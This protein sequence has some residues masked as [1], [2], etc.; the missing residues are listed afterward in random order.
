MTDIV[1]ANL[2]V[3]TSGR[4]FS[5][6]LHV[7]FSG[8]FL[9]G[10][11][12][13]DDTTPKISN[14]IS[15]SRALLCCLSVCS[16]NHYLIDSWVW[17]YITMQFCHSCSTAPMPHDLL[18]V[19]QWDTALHSHCTEYISNMY[20]I[21]VWVSSSSFSEETKHFICLKALN[22]DVFISSSVLFSR[23][24]FDVSV[25]LLHFHASF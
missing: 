5:F 17:D 13:P 16:W 10:S 14:G 9:N 21:C 7:A 15:Q 20:Y 2:V 8:Q 18:G 22:K 24:W 6:S 1:C 19:M 3:D 11:H 4:V 25:V 23:L 12:H